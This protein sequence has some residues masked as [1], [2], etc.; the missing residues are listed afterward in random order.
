MPPKLVSDDGRHMMIR[1]LAYVREEDLS[2]WAE[3][4]AFP[5]IPFDLCGSQ[6][7]LQRKQIKAMLREWERRHPGRTETVFT[8]LSDAAPSHLLDRSLFD[9]AGLAPSGVPNADGDRAFDP[10]PCTFAGAAGAES[11]DLAGQ[12]SVAEQRAVIPVV[13]ASTRRR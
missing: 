5:I 13:A 6:D 8:A 4:R 9:F 12:R 7:N 10:E 3:H 11:E 2:R 1:P